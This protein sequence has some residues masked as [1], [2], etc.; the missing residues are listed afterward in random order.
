MKLASSAVG[1]RAWEKAKV[2][3]VFSMYCI[4]VILAGS[5]SPNL[6]RARLSTSGI[7]W[8][9]IL[10]FGVYG[11]VW[12]AESLFT[13]K[14]KDV[15][16]DLNGVGDLPEDGLNFLSFGFWLFVG[17][18]GRLDS[19]LWDLHHTTHNQGV[20]VRIFLF[21]GSWV[22]VTYISGGT[23]CKTGMIGLLKNLCL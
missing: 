3:L 17:D 20:R 13:N 7:F 22:T 14:S 11:S 12:A 8:G 4:S 18:L 2:S 16:C 19:L 10:Y 6:K 21:V 23:D 5:W 15:R 9:S 1:G